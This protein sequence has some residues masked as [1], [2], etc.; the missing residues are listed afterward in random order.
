MS[1]PQLLFV[2]GLGRSGTSAL[3]EV[4]TAHP[5]IVL[6]LERYKRLWRGERIDE[7]SPDLF[8]RD[9]LLDFTDG[10]T[11]V[12]PE[13]HPRFREHYERMAAG[14]E[15]AAYVGDKMTTVRIERVWKNLPDARFVCIVRDPREVAASWE[16]RAGDAEDRFWPAHND[17]VRSVTRWNQANRRILRAVR[18]RPD[19]VAV[20]EH[21]SFFGS[22]DGR[23]LH[24][25]LDWLGLDPADSAD[26]HFD[27]ARRHHA[28]VLS[29]RPRPLPDH[30]EAHVAEH[31]D[32]DRYA[33]LLR[34]QLTGA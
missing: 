13:R 32:L 33:A 7:L 15:Q 25:L 11:T 30:V 34:L 17:G 24:R 26:T 21:A 9:R 27:H 8:E 5:G 16:A 19:R 2:A 6:G 4:L 10:L 3:A 14:F 31:A 28:D 12:V 22:P 1:T 18:S 23:P 20:V 29:T